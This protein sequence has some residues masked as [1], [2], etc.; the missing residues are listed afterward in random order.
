MEENQLM[1]KQINCTYERTGK[2]PGPGGAGEMNSR[3]VGSDPHANMVIGR[4]AGTRT[5]RD[6]LSRRIIPAPVGR[7]KLV[8]NVC[9][10]SVALHRRL[11][12]QDSSTVL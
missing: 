6:V 8:R 7:S 9:C 4:S 5:D 12:V 10:R 1:N 2:L 3:P 11:T